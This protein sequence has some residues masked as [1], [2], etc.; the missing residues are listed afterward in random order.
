MFFDGKS[1]HIAQVLFQMFEHG[2]LGVEQPSALAAAQMIVRL[3]AE[4]EAGRAFARFDFADFLLLGKKV[5]VAVNGRFAH[6]R[7]ILD[8][9]FVYL[10][11]VRV[12]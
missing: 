6:V 1:A 3:C 7:M 5:E 2:D 4:I 12:V 8:D 9:L 11:R 10:L